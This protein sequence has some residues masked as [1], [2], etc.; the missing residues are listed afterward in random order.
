[1]GRLVAELRD[2]E[3][4]PGALARLATVPPE[5]RAGVAVGHVARLRAEPLRWAAEG[6]PLLG[7][8]ASD[9]E[10]V[11]GLVELARHAPIALARRA[12]PRL[13]R[14]LPAERL[15]D[16]AAEREELRPVLEEVLPGAEAE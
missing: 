9:P 11:R 10:G 12:V 13:L 16:L 1:I 7:L 3:R 8:L 15:R 5:A 6:E 2:P 4:A 14:A